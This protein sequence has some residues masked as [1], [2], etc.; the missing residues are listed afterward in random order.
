M[1]R[2]G[3]IFAALGGSP[4]SLAHDERGATIM[5]FALI[6]PALFTLIF[7][8]LEIGHTLYMQGVLQGVVQKAGRDSSLEDGAGN[9][10]AQQAIIDNRVESQLQNLNKIAQVSFNRRF[11]RSFSLAAAAQA[12]PFTDTNGN[13]KCDGPDGGTPGES[14]VDN[15]NN[16]VWDKDGGDAGQG[17]GKDIVVYTVSISYPRLFPLDKLV[18]GS[19]T[20]NLSAKTVLTNQPYKNQGSYG[21]PTVR[22]CK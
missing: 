13:G 7:G 17:S 10:T 11:Y 1:T 21:T 2:P 16:G 20:T 22:Q 4:A 8:A 9:A 12:E 14:F 18:G 5:E 19:G 3:R 15:N 6:T